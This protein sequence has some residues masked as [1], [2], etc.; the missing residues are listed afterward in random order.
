MWNPFIKVASI[1][2]G[3]VLVNVSTSPWIFGGVRMAF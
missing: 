1:D 2:M 3:T